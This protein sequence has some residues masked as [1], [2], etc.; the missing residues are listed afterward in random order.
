MV[1]RNCIERHMAASR[2]MIGEYVPTI[3][4]VCRMNQF[5][6]RGA[7]DPFS[8]LSRSILTVMVIQVRRPLPCPWS[9]REREFTPIKMESS[10]S[11]AASTPLPLGEGRGEGKRDKPTIMSR[12]KWTSIALGRLVERPTSGIRKS[13]KSVQ[14]P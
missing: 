6:R 12:T 11:N 8:A 4:I 3:L 1:V 2:R 13:T 7:I 10:L 14:T 9:H 5:L